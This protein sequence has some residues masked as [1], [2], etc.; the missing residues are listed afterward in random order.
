MH[1]PYQDE[2]MR[3]RILALNGADE[4]AIYAELMSDFNVSMVVANSIARAAWLA[5][6]PTAS[7][8]VSRRGRAL[9]VTNTDT[10]F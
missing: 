8:T 2:K 4:T 7:R 5:A 1:K 9:P 3:A 10:D 6:N